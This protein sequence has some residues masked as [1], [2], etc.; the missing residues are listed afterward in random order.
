MP[1]PDCEQQPPPG[2]SGLRSSPIMIYAPSAGPTLAPS[3]PWLAPDTG[4][5]GQVQPGGKEER[6][7]HKGEVD[8]LSELPCLGPAS[9]SS[10]IHPYEGLNREVKCSGSP[11]W[12]QASPEGTGRGQVFM[13]EAGWLTLALQLEP[14]LPSSF[15]F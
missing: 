2:G 5:R 11:T 6:R 4:G 9:A 14:S 1:W 3:L 13:G 15:P 7:R 8:Q 10:S 12:P